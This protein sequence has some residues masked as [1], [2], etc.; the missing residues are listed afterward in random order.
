MLRT[1]NFLLMAFAIGHCHADESAVSITVDGGTLHGSITVP[2]GDGPV[3]V[4]MLHPGSGPT[5]RDGNNAMMKNDSLKL[6][7]KSLAENGVA[8]LRIDKRGI[9]E[10]ASAA[11]SEE[12]LRFDTYARDARGWLEMLSTDERFNAVVFLGHSEGSLVGGVAIA[13]FGAPADGVISL[14]GAGFPAADVLRKQMSERL[15]P[16]LNEESDRVLDA[17]E[18]GETVDDPPAA[19]FAVYRTSVQPY[20]ISWLKYDPA[21]VYS[22]LKQPV[23][24]IQGATDIQVDAADAKRLAAA[25]PYPLRMIEGMNHVLKKVGGDLQAQLPSYSDPEVPL[26]PGLVETILEFMDSF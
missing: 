23:L 14:A 10:S 16:Q 12:E 11:K 5:D 24:I 1:I 21:E 7:A 2:E 19:L 9:G 4:I 20:M 22:R 3:P 17:L 15:P 18:R 25:G 13:E 6:L 8:T 26:H